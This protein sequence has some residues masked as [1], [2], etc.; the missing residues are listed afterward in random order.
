[1]RLEDFK[2]EQEQLIPS[3]PSQPVEAEP[4]QEL[5]TSLPDVQSIEPKPEQELIPPA[6]RLILPAKDEWAAPAEKVP[7][8]KVPA[9]KV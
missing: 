7:A 4:E 8:E 2:I 9:G 3:P 5:P 1:M 6:P